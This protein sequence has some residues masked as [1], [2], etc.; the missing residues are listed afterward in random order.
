MFSRDKPIK[1]ISVKITA[2]VMDSQSIDDIDS[3][4]GIKI[5]LVT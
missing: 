5:R 4:A 3:A 2:I 1:A